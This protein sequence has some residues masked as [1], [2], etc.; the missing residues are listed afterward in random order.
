ME[1]EYFTALDFAIGGIVLAAVILADAVRWVYR[2]ISNYVAKTPNQIDDKIWNAVKSAVAEAVEEAVEEVADRD[3]SDWE[4]D[5]ANRE[6]VVEQRGQSVKLL[7][8][9]LS[10]REKKMS[11]RE[12]VEIANL[13]KGPEI[14]D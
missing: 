13:P 9:D 2:W 10:A 4:D 11:D 14:T 7:R 3:L 12:R 8:D 6:E 1:T 5:L